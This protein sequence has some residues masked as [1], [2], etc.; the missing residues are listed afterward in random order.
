MATIAVKMMPHCVLDGSIA[1][2]DME[3]KRRPY[4]RNCSCG[5]HKS[6]VAESTAC[7]QPRNVS[8]RMKQPWNDCSLSVASVKFPCEHYSASDSSV[9]DSEHTDGA[10]SHR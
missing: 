8:F 4:H 10:L 6:K 2:N 1:V 5:L 3:I 9:R 7:S